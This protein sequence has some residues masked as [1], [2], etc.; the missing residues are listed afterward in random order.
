MPYTGLHPFLRC[1]NLVEVLKIRRYPI[2]STDKFYN[3]YLQGL[4]EVNFPG[5]YLKV[6]KMRNING[7]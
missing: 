5:F 4:G 3:S 7:K 1:F 2:T 6:L